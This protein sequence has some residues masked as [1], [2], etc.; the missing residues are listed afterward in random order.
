MSKA[1]KTL[2]R[3]ECRC[4]W[5]RV[6]GSGSRRV[7]RGSQYSLRLEL[8]S[9]ADH[10]Q[11]L[12]DIRNRVGEKAAPTFGIPVLDQLVDLFKGPRNGDGS[13]QIA[14][15]NVSPALGTR[16]HQRPS[17]PIIDITSSVT[18]AG[19]THLLYCIATLA[20]LPARLHDIPLRGRGSAVVVLDTDGRFD[21]YRLAQ[22]MRKHIHVCCKARQMQTQTQ[23]QTQSKPGHVPSLQEMNA[24]IEKALDHVHILQPRSPR[25]LLDCVSGLAQYLL[26][27]DGHKSGR[28]RLHSIL[29]DSASTFQWEDR[30]E[31][32]GFTD[33]DVKMGERSSDDSY[34]RLA[35]VL[36]SLQ[37]RFGCAIVMTSWSFPSVVPSTAA[38]TASRHL[39]PR[40]RSHLPRPLHH[41]ATFK[42]VMNRAPMPQFPIDMPLADAFA[43]RTARQQVVDQGRFIARLDDSQADDWPDR[44]WQQ[45][46]CNQQSGQFYLYITADGAAIP[47]GSSGA[48]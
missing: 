13:R 31:E 22:T 19:K 23:T 26:D 21:A 5:E 45:L 48:V 3:D 33:H 24:V 43:D 2:L 27:C 18:G 29:L 1:M 7:P 34:R 36:H 40:L 6:V 38:T 16:M 11:L 44:V 37:Q 8:E 41:F 4:N 10:E 28:R 32:E 12:D 14:N 35:Q 47:D 20:T 46:S 30:A 17:A 39:P 15:N 42:F 9:I 25:E